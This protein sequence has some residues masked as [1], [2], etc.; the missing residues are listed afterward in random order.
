[1]DIVQL[2]VLKQHIELSCEPNSTFFILIVSRIQGIYLL[3]SD[4]LR[5]GVTS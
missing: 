5:K 3:D 1:M 2:L 4:I